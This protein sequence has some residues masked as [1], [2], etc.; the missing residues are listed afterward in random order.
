MLRSEW[1]TAGASEYLAPNCVAEASRDLGVTD[2]RVRLALAH[3]G[4]REAKKFGDWEVAARSA[5]QLAVNLVGIV[6]AGVV[7]LW[8]RPL[9]ARIS[10]S[11]LD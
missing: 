5:L 9:T 8:L 2:D 3:A 11:A 10:H 1:S 6:V 4:L 7:V